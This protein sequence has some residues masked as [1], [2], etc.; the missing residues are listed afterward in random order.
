MLIVGILLVSF[1]LMAYSNTG[2]EWPHPDE[3]EFPDIE[4]DVRE[5]EVF[6]LENGM[7]V[8]LME[9]R[10]L[11]LIKGGAYIDAGEIYSP[12]EKTGLAEMTANL[13]RTG[14]AGGRHPD[15]IDERLEYLAA[16]V[17]VN[18]Q[19]IFTY[20]SFSALSDNTEEVLN[21]YCDILEKPDFISE[22]IELRRQK[23]KESIRR[24]SDNPVR[25]ASEEFVKKLAENHPVGWFPT[26][27]TVDDINREDLIDFH[28]RYYQPQAVNLAI[29]GDFDQKE[30]LELLET[31]LGNWKADRVDYPELPKFP[32]RPQSKV[33]HVQQPIQQSIIFIGHPTVPFASEAYAPLNLANRILGSGGDNRLFREIRSKRGLAYSAGSYITQGLKYPG[34]FYAYAITGAQ[35]TGQTIELILAE[36]EKIKEELVSEEEL[37]KN[38]RAILNEAVHRYTSAH[39]ITTR[40]ALVDFVNLQPDYYERYIEQIQKV[41]KEDIRVVAEEE[42]RSEDAI[43]MVV[44][45]SE[46]FDKE[47][48][49]YGEVEA[50]ELQ[51]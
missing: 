14:G 36:I 38:R 31:T 17:E 35:N 22:R 43:M 28:D 34:F 41:D 42:L 1:S 2:E 13:L 51:F 48:N 27:D 46:L 5:A 19:S 50:I 26:H 32:T 25:L 10:N 23:L 9:N 6:E 40:Q 3:M 11:P 44:G 20:A 45:N 21:I 15:E 33:Y 16:S 12:Q 18:S 29:T 24:R 49:E 47:L 7:T 8:Y 39:E 30:M 37:Q 4:I